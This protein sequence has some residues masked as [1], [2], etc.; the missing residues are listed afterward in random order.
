MTIFLCYKTCR[1]RH[2]IYIENEGDFLMYSKEELAELIIKNPQEYNSYKKNAG[3][4]DLTELD[5]SNI[6]L[7]EIDFTNSELAGTSFN[8]ANIADCDFSGADLNAADF[9]RADI[10]GCNFTESV[11]AGADFSYA[12]VSGSDFTD[13][14][15]AGCIVKEADL[16]D[17]DFSQSRNLSAARAD[18]TTIWPD[19]EMLPDDF[20]TNYSKDNED[21]E[22]EAE[23]T[24]Y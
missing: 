12:S 10:S 20:D 11:L 23:E 19:N 2:Y 24:D 17:S 13:A 5:F 3:G 16:S 18:E 7:E 9:T 21:G 15:M 6:K 14:D 4:L 1:L 22:D 8:D